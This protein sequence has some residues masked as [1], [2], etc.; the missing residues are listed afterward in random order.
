M[1]IDITPH[2]DAATYAPRYKRVRDVV[3][4]EYKLKQRDLNNITALTKSASIPSPSYLRYINPTDKSA[5][6]QARNQGFI[7]GARLFNATSRTLSGMFG[8]LFRADPESPELNPQLDYLIDN[9]DGAGL[10][11]NQQAQATA[12][13]VLQVGRHGLLADMPRNDEGVEITQAD[14]ANGF[15]PT[16]QQYSA[17]NIWDWNESIINGSR[18][19]DY[20]VLHEETE[21]FC[22]ENRF[23]REKKEQLRVYRL[24]DGAVTVEILTK[25]KGGSWEESLPVSITVSGNRPLT[26]IP[27]TFPGSINNTPAPDLLPLEPLVDVNL[28][29]YQESANLRSSSYQLSAAQPVISDDNYQRAMSNKDSSVLDTGEDSAIVLGTGGSFMFA[30][31]DP[32]NISSDLMAKDE[33]RMVQLGAQLITSGG[34]AQTAEAAR[35]KHASD[36]ST[37]ENISVNVSKAYTD[38]IELCYD[39]MGVPYDDAKYSLNRD[40]FDS[41]LTAQD[42]DSLVRTWQAG[43]IS[44]AVLDDNLK[45]GNII[46]DAVDL[47]QMNEEIEEEL[48]GGISFEEEATSESTTT[49]TEQ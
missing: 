33:E 7:N 22:V 36:V 31:P 39:F 46:G 32:N 34:Q 16:I 10:S 23:K 19:L 49:T 9:V 45:D 12:W 26:V 17:E 48:Q 21:G 28:G 25:N 30:S 44:K 42:I 37:L 3:D 27:F 38:M 40:F 4:G 2:C 6:N 41:N 43:G 14:V 29:H 24:T 20:L 5:Y 18:K 11:L 15:R 1:T 47:E 13:N 35:I 8:M